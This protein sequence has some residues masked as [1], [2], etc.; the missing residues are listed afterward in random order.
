MDT[1]TECI[2]NLQQHTQEAVVEMREFVERE[3]NHNLSEFVKI[4]NKVVKIHMVLD[5]LPAKV[6]EC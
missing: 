3:K 6:V 2:N 1:N 5:D 4:Q